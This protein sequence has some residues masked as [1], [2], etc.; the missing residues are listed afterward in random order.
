MLA[1]ALTWQ[2]CVVS[3]CHSRFLREYLVAVSRDHRAVVVML[4]DR[5]HSLRR[6]RAA[7]LYEQHLRALEALQV[8][9]HVH[10]YGCI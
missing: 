9:A 7:P 5:L 1:W 6:A 3:I 8:C 10:I 4:A 2:K